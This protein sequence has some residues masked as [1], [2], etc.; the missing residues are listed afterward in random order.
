M[1]G[2]PIFLRIQ[3]SPISIVIGLHISFLKPHSYSL[4]LS[5]AHIVWFITAFLTKD[6]AANKQGYSF[7]LSLLFA[8]TQIQKKPEESCTTD[9]DGLNLIL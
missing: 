2:S 8:V 4:R 9:Q 1:H 5:L 6:C 3:D 7:L